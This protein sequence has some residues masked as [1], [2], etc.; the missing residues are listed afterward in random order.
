MVTIRSTAAALVLVVAA[1]FV[2]TSVPAFGAGTAPG[3]ASTVSGV[4]RDDVGRALQGVEILI[5]APEG[6]PGGVVLHALSDAAGRFVI[7]AITPG[8]YRVAAVK[9]GY[10]AALGRVN[11]LLR[12][13]VDLVLRPVPKDGQPGADK[14][15]D[16]L[17]WTLRVPPRSI[18]RDLDPGALLTSPDTG[19]V[20]A[21]A[22]R[23]QD[24][25]RGEVD[26]MVALGS[27]RTGASGP[28][29][30]LTGNETRMRVAG[31][32]GERGA[33]QLHGR[34]GSLDSSSRA[35]PTA[36]SRGASDVDLDLSYDTTVDESLAMRAF[37]SAG[38][39]F[40]N[41][42]ASLDGGRSARGGTTR[43]GES[44]SMPRRTS[45]SKSAS[46]TPASIPAPGTE[47]F[48]IRNGGM[49]R[50]GRSG[51]RDPTRTSRA[52]GISCASACGRSA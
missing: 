20:R 38:D 26:H 47:V 19:G 18:L 21:F 12:S 16:D 39:L 17:S 50:T 45:R 28:A 1:S 25:V 46:R 34:H 48:G 6:R 32:L 11:T 9:T 51:P 44:R 52:T 29:S 10:V 33:I 41:D 2:P 7:G 30:D 42:R 36:V 31:S 15:L 14:V 49:R 3:L 27:W 35:A 22:A 24:S 43:T 37:Y 13:S 23:V 5:L 40:V 8:V 4:V